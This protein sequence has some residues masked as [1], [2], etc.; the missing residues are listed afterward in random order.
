[1]SRLLKRGLIFDTPAVVPEVPTRRAAIDDRRV[2]ARLL[3]TLPARCAEIIGSPTY[4]TKIAAHGNRIE[5]ENFAS[6]PIM[7]TDIRAGKE[8]D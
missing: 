1:L 5:L 3:M 6:S 8:R 2:E 4:A 7:L